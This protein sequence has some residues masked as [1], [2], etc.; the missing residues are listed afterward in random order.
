M[1]VGRVSPRELVALKNGFCA[2]AGAQKLLSA[3]PDKL[4]ASWA[5][6]LDGLPE[7]RF[8]IEMTI[9]EEPANNI[10]IAKAVS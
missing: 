9:L 6:R 2:I 1:A 3:S 5:S 4:I 7:M 10:A 8:K